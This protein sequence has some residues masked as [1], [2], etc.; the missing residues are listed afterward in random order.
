MAIYEA[1]IQ[2]NDK[3]FEDLARMQYDLFCKSNRLGRTILSLA[4]VLLGIAYSESWW[5]I[6]VIGYGCYLMTSTYSSSNHT[7]H[8]LAKQIRAA[9]MDFPSSR[10]EFTEEGM[11][12]ITQPENKPLGDI[13][14]YGEFRKLGEDRGYFY[15]FRDQYGGYMIPKKEL[16]D[17]ENFRY[18][19]QRKSGLKFER[20][21]PPIARLMQKMKNRENEPYHL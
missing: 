4:A 5:G 11:Q 19:I 1:T 3:T 12:V 9:G 7:A 8:K 10:Y 20:K 13:M 16:E 6:L 18:F 21:M 15:I 14:P 2:H 17:Q